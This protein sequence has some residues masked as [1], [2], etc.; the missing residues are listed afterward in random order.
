MLC[1]QDYQTK[2][3]IN[4]LNGFPPILDL[5]RSDYPVVQHLALVALQRAT[6]DG[7]WQEQLVADGRTRGNFILWRVFYYRKT[8]NLGRT[9]F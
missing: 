4:E 3:A 1:F 8:P 5:L 2:S 7:E 9:L 6:Q